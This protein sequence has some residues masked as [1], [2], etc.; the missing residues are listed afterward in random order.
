MKREMPFETEAHA[1]AGKAAMDLYEGEDL[2]MV[3]A[4]LIPNYNP[5]RFDAAA[6]RI[7]QEHGEQIVT[8]C[9]G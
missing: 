8:L 5:N 4:K 3:A 6:I 1:L 7:F 9:C 2:N